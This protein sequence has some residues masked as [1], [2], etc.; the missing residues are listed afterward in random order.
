MKNNIK[1]KIDNFGRFSASDIYFTRIANSQFT[2]HRYS[3]EWKA[4]IILAFLF[5]L[6]TS[7][8]S[9][10][11]GYSYIHVIIFQLTENKIVTFISTILVVVFLEYLVYMLIGKFFKFALKFVPQIAIPVLI[12]T[13][14]VYSISFYISTQ[15]MS[16]SES[17]KVDKTELINENKSIE[18]SNLQRKTDSDID[19]LKNQIETIKANP[20]GWQNGQRIVLTREQLETIKQYNTS[21][22]EVKQ[23]LRTDIK[24]LE[25]QAGIDKKSNLKEVTSTASKYHQFMSIM[26]LTQ[27][28]A[29][30]FLMFSWSKIQNEN[31]PEKYVK[32]KVIDISL[33][34]KSLLN[35]FLMNELNT[36]KNGFSLA[37]NE[38]AIDAIPLEIETTNEPT[39]ETKGKAANS[40]YSAN[41]KKIG[42][43]M[44][45]KPTNDPTASNLKTC[46]HCGK[47][48]SNKKHWNA[49]FCNDLCRKEYWEK[50]NNS[51]L[52]YKKSKK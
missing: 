3:K 19:Y 16:I 48:I 4:A 25:K 10:S 43:Q 45:K 8:F 14:M 12:F 5:S 23:A 36:I 38:Y 31:E 17:K 6:I 20:A 52:I 7:W 24:D 9:I 51:K 37:L 18:I 34:Y 13:I 44:T 15:G 42:F 30:G 50:Q 40:N 39:N 26:M 11:G 46:L 2:T 1:N 32:S 22:N 49:K 27:F 29:G 33:Q 41:E 35:S 47:D 21:I 28:V